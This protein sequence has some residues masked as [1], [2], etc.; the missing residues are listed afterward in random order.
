[1]SQIWADLVSHICCETAKM[2]ANQGTG[3]DSQTTAKFPSSDEQQQQSQNFCFYNSSDIAPRFLCVFGV[4]LDVDQQYGFSVSV[5]QRAS[6]TCTLAQ[7][8]SLNL[9]PR[10]ACVSTGLLFPLFLSTWLLLSQCAWINGSRFL[11]HLQ[12]V[13]YSTLYSLLKQTHLPT[14]FVL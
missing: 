6:I 2:S 12:M 8:L 4:L 1:M 5:R 7:H 13:S 3:P 9:F 10:G 11:S 14:I